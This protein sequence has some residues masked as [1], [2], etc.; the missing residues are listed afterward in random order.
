MAIILPSNIQP[1]VKKHIDE[2]WYVSTVPELTNTP[3]FY[4]GMERYV[5]SED[6]IYTY[7][8]FGGWRKRASSTISVLVDSTV[9]LPAGQLAKV[10]DVSTEA[11]I[12]KLKFELPVGKGEK[13]DSIVG[14]PGAS[15]IGPIGQQGRPFSIDANGFKDAR[16]AYDGEGYPFTY[17]AEDTGEIS[18]KL[19]NGFW[20]EWYIWRGKGD[21]GNSVWLAYARNN[22]GLDA[23]F[24]QDPLLGYWAH[25]VSDTQPVL[26]DFTNWVRRI[27]IDGVDG[28]GGGGDTEY[29][30]TGYQK[31]VPFVYSISN[32]NANIFSLDVTPDEVYS[33]DVFGSEGSRLIRG[34]K[35]SRTGPLITVEE[36]LIDGD[37]IEIWYKKGN[38]IGGGTGSGGHIIV[39]PDNLDVE[40]RDRL[41][42]RGDLAVNVFNETGKT[43][44]QIDEPII[45][46]RSGRSIGGIAAGQVINN[47]S[48]ELWKMLWAPEFK[49]ATI[50]INPIPL[51]EKS[52]PA[53]VI[54]TGDIDPHSEVTINGRRVEKDGSVLGTFSSNSFSFNDN[55][56]VTT[57]Y[58]AKASVGGNGTP[59]V[60][61]DTEVAR[62][63]APSYYGVT[64]IPNPNEAECK[65]K[66][67]VLWDKGI[68]DIKFNPNNNYVLFAEPKSNGLRTKIT[69][70]NNFDTTFGFNVISTTFTLADGVTVEPYYIYV[71]KSKAG[72]GSLFTYK[73]N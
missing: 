11:G 64:N 24:Q 27:G 39:D 71:A 56:S 17:L 14:P 52:I 61:S 59:G 70:I 44:V 13:G 5:E 20:S 35:Y 62:F 16:T 37:L 4:L 49:G 18:F 10:T 47:N 28:T 57:S 72:D 31:R 73:F 67:K 3:Y 45:T 65:S 46:D 63:V 33:V 54:I 21:K 2:R 25:I 55:V 36:D 12:I 43:V 66:T 7:H 48:T 8:K 1:N 9:T 22:A 40:G 6:A 32:Q 69:D 42:F 51:F 15:V 60:I 50:N 29:Q 58:I 41:Q 23:S 19:E 38:I 53:T 30:P 34:A 26:S 68:R